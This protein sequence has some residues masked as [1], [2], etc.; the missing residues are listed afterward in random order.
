MKKEKN[1]VIL[2][3][4]M[5]TPFEV[6]KGKAIF[7]RK[8]KIEAIENNKKPLIK[9]SEIIDAEDGFIVPGFIDIHVHGG[10]GS[11]TMDGSLESIKQIAVTHS[12]FGTTAFLPTTMTMSERK[13]IKSLESIKEAFLKGT[14]AA[15]VLG[16]NL[17]GPYINPKKK[18]SQE[19]KDIQEA[20]IDQFLRFNQAS[21]N[22]IRMITLAPEM[23]G[24]TDFI[25][26]LDRQGIIVSVGHSDATYNQVQKGITA[27]V[28]HA[29][30]TF[31]AMRGLNHREPGVVGA[32]LSSPE[33]TLE[34]IADLVHLHPAI[35][36]ILVQVKEMEKLVLIT[37]AIRATNKPEGKYE[38]GGQEVTVVNGEARL[39]NGTLAGSILT[40]D[41]AIRNL[42]N[43]IEIPLKNAIQMGTHNPARRLGIESQ[44]GSLKIGKDA[45]IVILN[46]MLNVQLTM[47]NGNV[48]YRR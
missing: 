41:K 30:H 36:K 25:R 33:I 20:S 23:P 13:I 17:E 18:G 16:A 45:D 7:I 37:D 19:E 27:G 34:L 2:N 8:G 6:L 48:V 5:I 11:D 24:S 3:G 26:W 28:S 44:K 38:L 46:K 22:I 47:V 39:K 1:T 10:G 12:R 42:V 14:G 15:K 29:T 31:N 35:I 32:V 9:D 43:I 21:A 40:M 4:N